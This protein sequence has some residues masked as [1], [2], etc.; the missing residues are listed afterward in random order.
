MKSLF[1][2]NLDPDLIESLANLEEVV[3]TGWFMSIHRSP[4]CPSKN[5]FRISF[6][7]G[8]T[9]PLI[10]DLID[11]ASLPEHDPVSVLI[12]EVERNAW[13][14]GM[15]G[16]L[17]LLDKLWGHIAPSVR[18]QVLAGV[19]ERPEMKWVIGKCERG[20]P[21]VFEAASATQI[22]C[23]LISDKRL[24]RSAVQK[25]LS[26]ILESAVDWGEQIVERLDD[27]NGEREVRWNDFMEPL[28]QRAIDRCLEAAVRKGD[29][30]SAKLFL[31]A[32]AD[33]DVGIWRLERGYNECCCALSYAIE[34]NGE[35]S[36]V[37][38]LLD[39]GADP[40]GTEYGGLNKPLYLAVYCEKY[41]LAELLLDMGATFTGGQKGAINPYNSRRTP[42]ATYLS[43][44]KEP[45]DISWMEL[46]IGRHM[47]FRNPEDIPYFHHS[48]SQGGYFYSFLSI[49]MMRN[50]IA[51]LRKFLSHRLPLD[52]SVYDMLVAIASDS[53]RCL[54]YVL[55]QLNAPSEVINQILDHFPNFAKD[56]QEELKATAKALKLKEDAVERP[57]IAEL[58]DKLRKRAEELRLKLIASE[59]EDL[60]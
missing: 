30:E 7:E 49:L 54:P 3:P 36:L 8:L 18:G 43:M 16:N 4:F 52:L 44:G 23:N 35:D 51:I 38:S 42:I 59:Q 21:I 33:P 48:N 28:S 40:A 39:A 27:L 10:K 37:Q 20:N 34:N 26:F 41:D 2:E 6:T 56:R 50:D 25:T 19:S 55:E 5:P 29:A 12:K 47:F 1:T 24:V 15:D 53:S 22:C 17:L 46:F 32:G 45:T 11:E 9:W 60:S 13:L 31:A 57:S 14:F 58:E